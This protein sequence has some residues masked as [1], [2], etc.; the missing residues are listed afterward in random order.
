MTIP[1]NG[2][3]IAKE[4]IL[5]G[6]LYSYRQLDTN[7]LKV[8]EAS[9][10]LYSLVELLVAKGII[11]TNELEQHKEEV[12]KRLDDNFKEAGIGVRVRRSDTDKESLSPAVNVDCEKR[13][14]ICK[15]ACCTLAYP[16][17][18]QDINQGIRWCLARPFMNAREADGYCMHL[19]RDTLRCSIYEQRPL[20]CRQYS[21]HNDH[22]IWLD[23]DKMVI[24]PDPFDEEESSH[25]E[26]TSD[27]DQTWR[28]LS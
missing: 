21:C 16:L 10:D 1:T 26:S 4:E 2:H 23:F 7:A 17:S 20:V 28:G 11:S 15:A 27:E 14:H 19:E 25:T 24:N 5:E 18:V 6:F 8:Y 12:K 22:R 3:A 13:M 9:A